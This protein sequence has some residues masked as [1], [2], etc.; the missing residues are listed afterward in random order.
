MFE[1]EYFN[2][3]HYIIF[4][5]IEVDNAKKQITLAISNEGKMKEETFEL[6]HNKK[7]ESRQYFVY[8]LY[9]DKI[10]LDEFI[11]KE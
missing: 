9:L 2:G 5:I 11:Y 6:L 4:D 1:F 3:E 10:Y 8:G 7:D